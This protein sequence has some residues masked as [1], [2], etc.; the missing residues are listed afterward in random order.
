[1]IL[2]SLNIAALVGRRPS[3][4]WSLLTAELL[5]MI[6]C[7]ASIAVFVAAMLVQAPE[8]E[9]VP[10]LRQFHSDVHIQG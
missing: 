2:T 5:I 8:V 4:S 1:M 7:T 10:L 3:C 9:D 6:V